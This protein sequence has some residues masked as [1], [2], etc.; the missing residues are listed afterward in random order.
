MVWVTWCLLF[1]SL[2]LFFG[3]VFGRIEPTCFRKKKKRDETPLGVGAGGP[4]LTPAMHTSEDSNFLGFI[5]NTG[6][7]TFLFLK[8]RRRGNFPETV[9]KGQMQNRRNAER[10]RTPASGCPSIPAAGWGIEREKCDGIVREG[11]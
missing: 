5:A 2:G 6:M 4:V 10:A 9:F 3:L 1:P 11:R 7:L 8:A